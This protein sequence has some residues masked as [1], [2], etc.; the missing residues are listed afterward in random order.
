MKRIRRGSVL[1]PAQTENDAALR[2][3]AVLIKLRG[4]GEHFDGFEN[5]ASV[6]SQFGPRYEADDI[7]AVPRQDDITLLYACYDLDGYEGRAT[8]VFILDNK[9][10]EVH[11]S[12]CSCY[13][14]EGQWAPELTTLEALRKRTDEHLHEWLDKIGAPK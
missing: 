10:Y 5:R 11:G 1:L 7:K 4:G 2:A 14:L 6:F 13:G 9:L 12:H 8:V 3:A